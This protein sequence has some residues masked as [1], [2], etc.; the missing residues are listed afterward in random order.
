MK[1]IR[2][3]IEEVKNL[4]ED[5]KSTELYLYEVAGYTISEF[6]E[7]LEA[8]RDKIGYDSVIEED[9]GGG[10]FITNLELYRKQMLEGYFNYLFEKDDLSIMQKTQKKNIEEQYLKYF[11]KNIEE[12][13][14]E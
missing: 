4:P 1:S 5:A 10:F 9:W 2:D 7:L 8:A 13:R 11:G 12:D 3:K 14:P 6:I